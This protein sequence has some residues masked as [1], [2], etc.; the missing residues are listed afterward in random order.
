MARNRCA[1]VAP[2]RPPSSTRPASGTGGSTDAHA[3]LALYH[4]V[5]AAGL[6]HLDWA[7]GHHARLRQRALAL[8][9]WLAG[10]AEERDRPADAVREL[11][12][13]IDLDPV[14]EARYLRAARLLAGQGRRVGALRL[15][16]RAR[17]TLATFDL[18]ASDDLDRLDAYLTRAAG[19]PDPAWA[20]PEAN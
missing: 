5:V 7:I 19:A 16:E 2:R 12:A 3:A 4:D 15:L 6:H 17:D 9:D 14:G 10:H 18:P 20:G 1:V 11:M 8:R 13:A